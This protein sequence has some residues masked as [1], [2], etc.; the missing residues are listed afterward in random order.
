MEADVSLPDIQ[1]DRAKPSLPT[2]TSTVAPL[3]WGMVDGC[4]K[5]M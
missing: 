3:G 4:P 2:S 1:F 5:N